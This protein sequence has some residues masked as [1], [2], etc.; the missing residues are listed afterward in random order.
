MDAGL[1]ANV[2]RSRQSVTTLQ[3][4]LRNLF[5][6]VPPYVALRESLELIGEYIGATYTAMHAMLGDQMLSEEWV[7]P[8]FEPGQRLRET[9]NEVMFD[10]MATGSARCVRLG[11]DP[12]AA[13]AIMGASLFDETLEPAGGATI[14]I[15][16]CDR[17]RALEALAWFEAIIGFVSVLATGG[18]NAPAKREDDADDQPSPLEA[19]PEIASHPMRL[20]FELVSRL[21]NK[22]GLA[23]VAIGF[24]SNP[25]RERTAGQAQS[26]DVEVV[27]AVGL[28]EVRASNPG[29]KRIRAAMEECLDRGEAVVCAAR[30][31]TEDEELPPEDDCRL[32]AQWSAHIGGDPVGSFPLQFRG[33]TV[34][35]VSVRQSAARGLRRASLQ[36]FAGE[37][38]EFAPLVP[39][40]R[41]AHRSVT[42]HTFDTVRSRFDRLVGKGR[43]KLAVYAAFCMLVVAG[44]TLGSIP[45]SLT[46]PCSVVPMESRVVSSPREGILLETF[47]RPGDVVTEGQLLARLDARED[48]LRVGEFEAQ[49][50]ALEAEADRALAE[51]DAGTLR[52][53]QSRTRSVEAELSVT[54]L[55]ISQAEIRAPIG[56]KVLTG[57]LRDRRGGRVAMGETLLQVSGDEQLRIELRI[58]EAHLAEVDDE[59]VVHFSPNAN[60]DAQIEV[61]S[62]R[63]LPVSQVVG[64]QNVFLAE[65]AAF[66]AGDSGLL[67]GME[68]NAHVDLGWRQALWVFT[69]RVTDW[70]HLRFWL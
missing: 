34:A 12:D 7:R 62:V 19:T 54:R 50:R 60:P 25:A 42:R 13:T 43:R 38:Q 32:H 30:T 51:G 21:Q 8:G 59:A 33:E 49:L 31:E 11:S 68:G 24:V 26:T 44:L 64:G 29:V 15:G 5:R 20:A 55:R 3:V 35:V 56:G 17:D 66:D 37:L 70:M 48:Q 63:V 6:A 2:E 18:G 52:V 10:S 45:Y 67:P 39:L 41:L 46:V 28:D 61:G 4:E 53:L 69:H 58:P 1:L 23:Q 36:M 57:D 65:S 47:V 40:A 14:L 9:I 27:A 16:P 22:H